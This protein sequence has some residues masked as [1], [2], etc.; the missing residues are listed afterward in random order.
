MHMQGE[1]TSF[2]MP[3]GEGLD[4]T[5]RWIRLSRLV[6]WH[7]VEGEYGKRFRRD[8]GGHRPLTARVALGALI[9]K[10]RLGLTD[11]ETVEQIRENPY[12]QHFLG[13]GS[14]SS[15]A[16]FDASLMTHFRKRL[17]AGFI[18]AIN[19]NLIE[20]HLS[21]TKSGIADDAGDR[22]DD[23]DGPPSTGGHGDGGN[24][25]ASPTAESV[26][27]GSAS[28]GGTLIIDA[29]CAPADITYP[30]DLK[31]V[32]QAREATERI[33]DDLHRP[34]AGTRARPRTHRKRARKAFVNAVKSKKASRAARRVAVGK[35]LRF[36]RRN[37]RIIREHVE[38][39]TW[40]LS[41]LKR[42]WYTKLLVVAEVYRQQMHL[43]RSRDWSIPD[44]IVSVSQ[45]HVRPI[46]RGKAGVP[47]EFG[48]K[49][50][51]SW[52]EGFAS[53]DHLRWDPYHEGKD[54]PSQAESY[55]A[56]TGRY[57]AVIHADKAYTTRANRAWC[58]ERGIRLAGIGPGRPPTDPVTLRERNR[59]ARTDEAARQPIEG[60][61]GRGKRRWS[62]ARIMAKL[63]CTSATVIAL[64]FLVM[65]LE[66]ML[67]PLVL[68]LLL[69]R[70]VHVARWASDHRAMASCSGGSGFLARWQGILLR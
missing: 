59:Q 27:P 32:N 1:Q 17:D 5:N 61:F 66:W 54:L 45:P 60:I 13:Y 22:D 19:A 29:T 25:V 6:P 15:A 33:I 21:T 9:I 35:Q 52:V 70:A 34:H 30:T 63:A 8:R 28:V 69:T 44:R 58:T 55:H 42:E 24:A 23:S 50:S 49:I 67:A 7:L 12:L 26:A 36:L 16:P 14:F 43:Y 38:S 68:A 37:L 4:P 10:E 11:R 18:T 3:L 62:L 51:V 40:D 41:L 2:L 57:P 48:A 53:L 39:G 65:N 31:V 56:R 46:V 64:V 20:K 47:V